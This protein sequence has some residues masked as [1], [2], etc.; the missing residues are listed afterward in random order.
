MPSDDV[1]LID[2]ILGELHGTA[3]GGHLGFRKMYDL[4]KSRFWWPKMRV[5]VDRYCR[6]CVVC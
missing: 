1:D 3:L 6:R 5:D 2:A 4:C